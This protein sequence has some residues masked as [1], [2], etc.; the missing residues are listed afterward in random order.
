MKAV[1]ND[2]AAQLHGFSMPTDRFTD[3]PASWTH[4]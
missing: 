4:Q 1:I 2:Q 3:N